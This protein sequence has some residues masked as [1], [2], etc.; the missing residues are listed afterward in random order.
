[1]KKI[2]PVLKPVG[3]STYDIIRAFRKATGFQGKVGHGGTLD[4]FASGVVLLLLGEA[5][6]QFEEIKKWQ[7][8]YL[9]GIRLGAV[10]STQDVEGEIKARQGAKKQT[11]QA[12]REVLRGFE[13]EIEQRVP[14]F[15]AAKHKGQPF[16]KLAQ[17]GKTVSRSKKVKIEQLDFIFY[18][19]PLL[20][21][22]ATVSGGTYIRQIASD[23]G[24]KLGCGG[25]L[26]FLQREKVGKF[27]LKSCC[28][29]EDFTVT[30]PL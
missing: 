23:I 30:R 5:T 10:S 16:Y 11:Q 13:G 24:E 26:Y 21:L 20:T 22:R 27:N 1:M 15:S 28:L 6:K 9:A 3:F 14:M 8:V 29:V 18:K 2:L 25:F 12:I 17:K 19:W 4:P 7:K